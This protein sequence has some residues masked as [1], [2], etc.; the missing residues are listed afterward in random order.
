METGVAK[1]P[2]KIAM[3]VCYFGKIP[4]YFRFFAKSCA[5]NP[6][7][8]FFLVTD[9]HFPEKL[10]DNIIIVRKTLEE[11]R[12]LAQEK[13]AFE[14]AL[15]TPYK[16]CDFKPAYG[17]LFSE[18]LTEYDFWGHGD[19]DVVYGNIRKFI[20]D[21]M[22]DNFDVIC[23]RPEY[24]PGYFTLFRNNEVGQKL[25]MHSRDYKTVFQDAE[26]FCFDETN[27]QWLPVIEGKSI[28]ELK[29]EIQSM[30]YVVK[31]LAL[32]GTIKAYFDMLVVEGLPGGLEWN[33]GTLIVR[34]GK[35]E[36]EVM[37]YHFISFKKLPY[38]H[39]PDWDDLPDRFYISRFYM[40]TV[41]PRTV[42]GRISHFFLKIVQRVVV[43]YV[44]SRVF[45]Q[46]KLKCLKASRKLRGDQT[47]DID[48]FL[49]RYRL[50]TSLFVNIEMKNGGLIAKADGFKP[51]R[52]LH[53]GKN[54][55]LASRFAIAGILDPDI[56]LYFNKRIQ[57]QT[58]LL[59]PYKE[60]TTVLLKCK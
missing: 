35:R 10:P 55:F 45:C 50:G 30:T 21:E 19:L 12:L 33:N 29:C 31:K 20:T 44:F 38:R 5:Y 48:L 39:V 53:R 3:I 15:Y 32:C 41:D 34:K 26:N 18:L 43:T 27:W 47:P 1:H 8:D 25:F 59:M 56:E 14:V 49:G 6:D 22:M 4:W 2:R 42:Q 51:T 37:L 17:F 52:L 7:V 57:N 11:I 36:Q 28:F 40:S 13:F 58:V 54:R 46:W 9:I 16:L 23:S 60:E 24:V